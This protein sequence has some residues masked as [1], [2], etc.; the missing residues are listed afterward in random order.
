MGLLKKS[1]NNKRELGLETVY[2]RLEFFRQIYDTNFFFFGRHRATTLNAC[3]LDVRP[4]PR[5]R[6]VLCRSTVR[7]RHN[8]YRTGTRTKRHRGKRL[9]TIYTHVCVCSLSNVFFSPWRNVIFERN[10]SCVPTE[11]RRNS[12]RFARF[13]AQKRGL[14]RCA[15]HNERRS[16]RGRRR[17]RRHSYPAH[18]IGVKCADQVCVCC[19][20]SDRFDRS[21]DNGPGACSDDEGKM[22]TTIRRATVCRRYGRVSCTVRDSRRNA[23]ESRGPERVGMGYSIAVATA[24]VA[25]SEN[26]CFVP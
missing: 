7:R 1:A 3:T 16:A 21:L 12:P 17:H 26:R 11:W 19:V 25:V 23:L 10:A 22:K 5:P 18:S 20:R 9:K 14:L 2:S 13:S 6:F 15:A 24:R 8:N 4:I